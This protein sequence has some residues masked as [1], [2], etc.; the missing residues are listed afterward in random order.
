[1]ETAK[2]DTNV[3]KRY[4]NKYVFPRGIFIARS[5]EKRVSIT[6]SNELNQMRFENI[7]RDI[8]RKTMV[9]DKFN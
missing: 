2:I 1:M 4:S 5:S 6:N 7:T 8:R 3:E 9:L